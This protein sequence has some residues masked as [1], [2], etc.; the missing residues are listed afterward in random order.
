MFVVLTLVTRAD[1]RVAEAGIA[2]FS[3]PTVVHFGAALFVSAVLAAPWRSLVD[4]FVL[5]GAAGLYGVVYSLRIMYRTR[6]Q[7]FYVADREDWIWYSIMPFVSYIAIFAGAIALLFAPERSIVAL[8]G[9]VLL[10]IFIGLRNS[11]DI[12]TYIASGRADEPP[13]TKP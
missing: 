10:L 3:T 13:S 7:D 4:V 1:R 11:W 6:H 9:S 2:T 12:V 8:A 5:A